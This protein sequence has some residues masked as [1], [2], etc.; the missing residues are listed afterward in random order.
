MFRHETVRLQ[1]N[2]H[3]FI[4]SLFEDLGYEREIRDRPIVTQNGWIEGGFFEDR[5]DLGQTKCLWKITLCQ[6]LVERW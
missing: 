4:D 5:R 3:P 2:Q 6:R 1:M